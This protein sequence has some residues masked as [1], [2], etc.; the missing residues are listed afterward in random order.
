MQK[1]FGPKKMIGRREAAAM[2]GVACGTLAN[3]LSQRRGPRAYKVGRKI[4]YKLEDL[5]LFFTANP[6]QTVDSA[7]IA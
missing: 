6:L 4:L 7:E 5:E 1:D 2:Y 3:M